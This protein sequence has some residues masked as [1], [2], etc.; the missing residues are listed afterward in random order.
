MTLDADTPIG[1]EDYT[2]P[3]DMGRLSRTEFTS[4]DQ[5]DFHKSELP[6]DL[7]SA[8]VDQIEA[9]ANDPYNASSLQHEVAARGG[10]EA[11]TEEIMR[12]VEALRLIGNNITRTRT[13]TAITP[14]DVTVR[15]NNFGL[16]A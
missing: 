8:A 16:A 14:E 13:K 15:R 3:E 10:I 9:F 5:L 6:R 1:Y 7:T 12:E 2:R 11:A 4:G